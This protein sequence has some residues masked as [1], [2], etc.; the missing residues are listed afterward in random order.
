V[1]TP[2]IGGI[3]YAHAR[4]GNPFLLRGRCIDPLPPT[5]AAREPLIRQMGV[6]ALWLLVVNGMIGAGI[7]GAPADTE[8]L[9]GSFS[10]WVFVLC[11][12]LIAPIM[13]CFAQLSSLVRGT[14]GPVLY[15]HTA[16]GPFVGFQIGWAFYV[17]RLSAFA[18]NLNLL[19]VSIGYF[20][21]EPM[22]PVMRITLLFT[23]CALIVWMNLVG[24]RA[25]MR[26]LGVLT[27][28]K[29]LPIIALAGVGVFML[30]RAVVTSVARPPDATDLGA[31]L[32][33][34]IYAY[35]GFES[36]LVPAGES[37]NPQRDMPRA[38]LLA[39]VIVC[40]LYVLV[41]IAAQRLLPDLAISER[42]IVDAGEALLGRAGAVIVVLAIVASVGGNLVGSM[43]SSPR[44]T[45]RLALDG[46]LPPAF[47]SIHP[48]HGTPWVSVV[49]YGA[50]SFIL[51]ATGS[52]VWLAVLSV[53]TRLLIYMTCIAATPR[54]RAAAG[55]EPGQIRLPGGPV[56]PLCAMVICAALLTRVGLDSVI[57]TAALLLVGTALFRIA[58]IRRRQISR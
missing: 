3:P 51:A 7:F 56:I 37:K 34:V 6:V 54:V 39:L 25:A 33:L 41:Q 13:L 14:G 28:L 8:R 31:A 30:D 53:F 4:P 45:Y 52:F 43:F 23:L 11:G 32:L 44:I 21:S 16:F 49:V 26:S 46:Q 50:A 47:A 5:P 10:P 12:V 15:T 17:A 38:L 19:V 20:W 9:A 40:T 35:V 18:A 24:V 27:I 29:F 42:P 22:G 36:G 48:K 57:A 58:V 2:V 55:D 1:I